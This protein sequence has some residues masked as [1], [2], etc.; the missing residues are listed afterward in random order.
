MLR[1][2]AIVSA[3]SSVTLKTASASFC[4]FASETTLSTCLV[5]NFVAASPCRPALLAA[6]VALSIA[7]FVIDLLYVETFSIA[8]P[9]SNAA[10]PALA[11]ALCATFAVTLTVVFAAVV[12]ALKTFNPGIDVMTSSELVGMNQPATSFTS[13]GSILAIG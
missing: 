13:S 9:T 1:L 7:F 12:A 5:T 10:P 4:I 6:L 11:A 8:L 3:V 2:A